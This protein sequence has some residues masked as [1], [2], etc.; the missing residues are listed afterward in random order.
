M[1]RIISFAAALT[2]IFGAAS[3]QKDNLAGKEGDSKVLFSFELPEETA[4]KADIAD[5]PLRIPYVCHA[6]ATGK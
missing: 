2:L 4:T 6:S 1:K 5:S 3:C